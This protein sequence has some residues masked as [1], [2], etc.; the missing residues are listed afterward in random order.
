MH[1]CLCRIFKNEVE[2]HIKYPNCSDSNRSE[3]ISH[4]NLLNLKFRNLV[5]FRYLQQNHRLLLYPIQMKFL[6]SMADILRKFTI[7]LSCR[8]KKF[9]STHKNFTVAI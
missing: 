8:D 5:D 2:D 3:I 1:R 4:Q 6:K 9:R 7:Q